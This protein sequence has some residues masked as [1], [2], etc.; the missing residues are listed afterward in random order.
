MNGS[1]VRKIHHHT[2]GR[3]RLCTYLEVW[4]TRS[5]TF[6]GRGV[7]ALVF[8]F[9]CRRWLGFRKRSGLRFRKRCWFGSFLAILSYVEINEAVRCHTRVLIDTAATLPLWWPPANVFYIQ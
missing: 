2:I 4:I 1:G 7:D 9:R 6:L 8:N 5:A 3:P